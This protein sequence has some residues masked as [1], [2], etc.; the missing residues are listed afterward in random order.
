[1]QTVPWGRIHDW[2][3]TT[4]GQCCQLQV[5]LTTAEWLS[6]TREYGYGIASQQTEGFFISKTIDGWCPFLFRGEHSSCGLQRTKP[7][8]CKLWPFRISDY[9]RYGMM[10]ESRFHHRGRVFYVY[11]IPFCRG[12][13]YGTPTN[14]FTKNVL[15]E[16]IDA[17]L[18]LQPSQVFTTARF[19]MK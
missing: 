2:S 18:G 17:R 12:F 15:P 10:E 16:F 1:M 5:Q 8:A 19:F 6:L 3:C 13:R 4:C 9:P 11:G 14:N 7:L